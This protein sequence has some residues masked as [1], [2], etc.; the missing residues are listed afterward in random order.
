MCRRPVDGPR[1]E[2]CVS[3]AG[4]SVSGT[5]HLGCRMTSVCCLCGVP[6]SH[7]V[8]GI[9]PTSFHHTSSGRTP[10]PPHLTRS[11]PQGVHVSRPTTCFDFRQPP[12]PS[13][14]L[15]TS[16][17]SS[18]RVRGTSISVRGSKWDEQKTHG[19]K[20]CTYSPRPLPS[21]FPSSVP[22]SIVS[23]PPPGPRR[24][25]EG[26]VVGRPSPWTFP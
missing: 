9:S 22:D 14:R 8:D 13:S 20:M 23:R 2:V 6:R 21:F 19:P 17:S 15:R 3:P 25:W 18:L 4:P 12:G 11:V 26:G 5:P 16:G 1:Y 24:F 10:T 7:T